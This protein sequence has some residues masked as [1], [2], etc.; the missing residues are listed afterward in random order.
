MRNDSISAAVFR[1]LGEFRTLITRLRKGTHEKTQAVPKMELSQ[2]LL[3]WLMLTKDPGAMLDQVESL[4]QE[5]LER[6]LVDA[7]AEG[8][9]A[10]ST[11]VQIQDATGVHRV[12]I[13]QVE[14]PGKLQEAA[15]NR[16][17]SHQLDAA[18]LLELVAR[19]SRPNLVYD[20]QQTAEIRRRGAGWGRPRRRAGHAGRADRRVAGEDHPRDPAEAR[21]L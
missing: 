13:D 19:L 5:A 15:R 7:N 11:E 20:A 6:G 8:I 16:A 1:D 12:P 17:L 4:L 9:F 21:E 3:V 18:P 2:D 14:T 10:G